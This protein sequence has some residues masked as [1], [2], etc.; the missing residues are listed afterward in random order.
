MRR[1]LVILAALFLAAVPAPVLGQSPAPAGPPSFEIAPGVVA[2]VLALMQG[3]PAVV[4]FRFEPG[5]TVDLTGNT[6]IAVATI[7]SGA[8]VVTTPV[9]LRVTDASGST[10]VAPAET[11]NSLPQGDYFLIPPGAPGHVEN[12]GTSEAAMLVAF[13][14]LPGPTGSGAPAASA[15]PNG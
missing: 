2:E 6:G 4:R 12:H 10:T 9:D 8:L 3:E 14:P 7:E 11:A 13:L 15:S 1:V 5:S